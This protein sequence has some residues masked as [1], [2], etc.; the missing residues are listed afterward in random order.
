MIGV[1]LVFLQPPLQFTTLRLGQH[2]PRAE[3]VQE[4]IERL[5]HITCIHLGQGLTDCDRAIAKVLLASP[6]FHHLFRR[7]VYS[8]CSICSSRNWRKAF[9]SARAFADMRRLRL[10]SLAR[11]YRAGQERWLMFVAAR[12]TTYRVCVPN[13]LA[14]TSTREFLGR[15]AHVLARRFADPERL[16][17]Q[18]LRPVQRNVP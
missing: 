16:D 12:P 4:F 9:S 1:R 3:S 14:R 13:A 11:V 15:D 7:T 5:T 2:G 17:E 10:R 6:E 18:A 8:T